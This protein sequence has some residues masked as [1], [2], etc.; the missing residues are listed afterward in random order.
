MRRSELEALGIQLPV[1]PT[2]VLGA[3]PGPPEWAARLASIGV[4]VLASGAP[5][6]TPDTW[7]AAAEAA[8][9]RAVMANPGDPAALAAAGAKLLQ[10]DLPA[11]PGTYV[12]G[13][14]DAMVAIVDGSSAEVED[15]NVIGR[16]VVEAVQDTPPAQLWV[17]ATPGLHLLAEDVVEAKLR[18]LCE[19]TYQARLAIAKIQFE[20]D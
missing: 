14:G 16:L 20:M 15:P 1:L 10:G 2:A 19:A 5:E 13:P 4:D 6:D 7:R 12:L 8:P 9:Y 3:L 18:A 17:V 11:Q